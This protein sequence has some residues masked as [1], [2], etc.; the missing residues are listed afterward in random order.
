[1]LI[2]GLMIGI[3]TG[4]IIPLILYMFKKDIEM[5][6]HVTYEFG[7]ENGSEDVKQLADYIAPANN[8]NGVLKIIDQ[9]FA[10]EG[11]FNSIC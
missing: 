4:T 5:L 10:K 7:M 11:P 3:L 9:Y 8:Q 1:M 6:K 2:A